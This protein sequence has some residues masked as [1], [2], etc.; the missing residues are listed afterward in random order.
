MI[1]GYSHIEID[2]RQPKRHLPVSSNA[3]RVYEGKVE[4]GNRRYCDGSQ[5]AQMSSR[6]RLNLPFLP[7]TPHPIHG[8]VLPPR[9]PGQVRRAVE[10]GRVLQE[11]R[12]LYHLQSRETRSQVRERCSRH[13]KPKDCR[14]AGPPIEVLFLKDT[15]MFFFTRTRCFL[16]ASMHLY[17][18][19]CRPSVRP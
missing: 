18:R 7:P 3:E 14:K 12:R 6:S 1:K 11:H 10:D 8:R 5:C 19:V 15:V 2:W 4:A 16:D 13:P 17:R 9:A